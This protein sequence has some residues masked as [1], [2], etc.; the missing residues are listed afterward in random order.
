MGSDAP[1]FADWVAEVI[2]IDKA[3]EVRALSSQPAK[4]IRKQVPDIAKHYR[5]QHKLMQQI[6]ANGWQGRIEFQPYGVDADPYIP[7]GYRVAM[8]EDA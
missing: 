8:R 6:R 5:R 7:D 2:G 4:G 1:Y 3:F